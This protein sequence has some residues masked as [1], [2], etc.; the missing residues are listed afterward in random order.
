MALLDLR[1]LCAALRHLRNVERQLG[2]DLHGEGPRR[3]DTLASIALT[4]FWVTVTGG[5]VLFRRDR[6]MV[7]TTLDLPRAAVADG[8]CVVATASVPATQPILGIMAFGLAGLACSALFAAGDQL[9]PGRVDHDDRG[10]CGRHDR[11]LPDGVRHCGV[12][13]GPLQSAA[14][15]SLAAIFRGSALVAVALAVIAFVIAGRAKASADSA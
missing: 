15:L 4:V 7:S 13:V 5:R 12:R 14:G 10:R 9:R 11:L 1:R 3:S 8:D 6:K 2:Q